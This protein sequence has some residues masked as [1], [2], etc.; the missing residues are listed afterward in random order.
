MASPPPSQPG[1]GVIG[2]IAGHSQFP[3]LFARAARAQGYR[4][5]AVAHK[6]ETLPELEREV[7]QITW[8]QLGQLGKLIKALKQGGASQ[9][10]MCGGVTKTRMFKDVKPDLKALTL[11]GKLRHMSDDG[12]LRTLAQ[13]LAD[14]GIT[15]LP[16]HELV[17]QLLAA[18]GCY[19]KRRPDE[20]E[21]EDARVG[22]RVAGQLGQ[23]DIG[24]AVV[25]AGRAVVAVEAIEGTDACIRRGGSLAAGR[26]VVVKRC[27]PT[28]DQRFDLPSVGAGT[29]L[30]MAE[31]GC[32]CLIIEAGKTLVFDHEEMVDRAEAAGICVQAWSEEE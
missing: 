29:V 19:T 15:I 18:P 16:S 2:L 13:V 7:D 21:R 4:V 1:P 5:V 26:A 17:P 20:Q 31:S 32:S 27:K 3:L 9:A 25:V 30:A 6:G 24:Q 8:V 14:E 11:V 12:I 22:W 23:L 28:Q 10:V